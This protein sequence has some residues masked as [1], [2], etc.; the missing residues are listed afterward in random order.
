MSRLGVCA[1]ALLLVTAGCLT[2]PGAGGAESEPA[3]QEPGF[4]PVPADP[5][6]VDANRGPS[7]RPPGES[8]ARRSL[9]SAS[10]NPWNT[11]EVVVAIDGPPGRTDE[12]RGAVADA[13]EF[14]NRNDV[15]FGKYSANFVL[16]P[17][18]R[19][20]DVVVEFT[21]TV[22]CDSETG[23]L[24]CAPIL[25]ASSRPDRPT[26]V[27]IDLAHGNAS[28]ERTVKHEFGHLLGIR[29]GDAPMPLMGPQRTVQRV[30]ETNVSDRDNPWQTDE[31]SV[32]VDYGDLGDERAAETRIQIQR[33]LDYY[34]DGADG[35][36]PED[37]SFVETASREEADVV[38]LFYDD[39]W[40]RD[41]PGSCGDIRGLDTDGDGAVEYHTRSWIALSDVRT[42]AIGWHVGYWL[43]ASMGADSQSELAPPFHSGANRTGDWWETD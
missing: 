32:Y 6:G 23:W 34:N 7:D 36:V 30:P 43:G 20:P 21:E 4:G 1:V 37:V 5:Y 11:D 9:E 13:I 15:R 28:I 17:D 12:Y 10:V 25:N 40:C 16:D 22:V 29:H 31:I 27:Q 33:A 35:T 2:A 8:P 18:A 38:V 14:W 24:G 19:D 41:G 3:V 26:T 39:P 42:R